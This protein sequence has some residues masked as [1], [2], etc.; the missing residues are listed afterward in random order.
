MLYACLTHNIACTV[1]RFERVNPAIQP[2]PCICTGDVLTYE[3]DTVGPGTTMWTGTGFSDC[4]T[5]DNQILL[6]HILFMTET[7]SGECNGGSVLAQG[8]E[9]TDGQCYRSQLNITAGPHFNNTEV[10]CV[11][12]ATNGT[13]RMIGSSTIHISGNIHI[14]VNGPQHVKGKFV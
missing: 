12:I 6:P 5:Q 2:M 3:C 7:A 9:V 8:I 1:T 14:Q 11:Y 10:I 4:P 13:Q